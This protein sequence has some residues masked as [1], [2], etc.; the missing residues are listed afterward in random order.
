MYWRVG[1]NPDRG[2]GVTVPSK[3][4]TRKVTSQYIP[5]TPGGALVY[6]FKSFPHETH[7][8]HEKM[9]FLYVLCASVRKSY[10]SVCSRRSPRGGLTYNFNFLTGFSDSFASA[11][12]Y[13]GF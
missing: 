3:I 2:T 5:G 13:L 9:V 11:W 4:S 8:K 12:G 6:N 7:E 1:L 10:Q